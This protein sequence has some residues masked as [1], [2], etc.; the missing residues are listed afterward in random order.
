MSETV[1]P[2]AERTHE[3]GL[4]EHAVALTIVTLIALIGNTVGPDVPISTAVP[5]M[6][7]ILG[8]AFVGV[9]I[10]QVVPLGVPA[11]VW[12]S[13]VGILLSTPWTPGSEWIVEQVSQ[14]EFLA[15]ATPILVYA[16]LGLSRSEAVRF[17]RSGWRLITVAI[18]VFIGTY[19]GSALI[20]D[21]ILNVTG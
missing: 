5:G 6:L 3:M 2:A 8:I 9:V 15:L 7:I 12:I 13:G 16:G 14:V 4:G 10:R 20:A 17:A 18:L 1:P 19:L 21:I 11:I